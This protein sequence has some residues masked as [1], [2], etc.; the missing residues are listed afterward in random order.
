MATRTTYHVGGY[1][2]TKPAQNRAEEWTPTGYTRWDAAGTQIQARAL[3]TAES[4]AL[5]DQDTVATASAND[6]SLRTKASNAI[7]ANDAFLA[8]AS[9]TNAQ[10]VAHVQRLTRENTALIRLV[11]GQLDSTNG[12]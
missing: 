12:T 10:V 5:A 8:I 11:I 3:T 6:A 4:T 2:S 1:D 9:P 7:A